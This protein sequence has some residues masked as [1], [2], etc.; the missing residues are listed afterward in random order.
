MKILWVEDFGGKLA[1]SKIAAAVFGELL[2]QVDLGKILKQGK[3]NVICQLPEL[4]EKHSIHQL[5]ICGSY[6]DWKRIYAEQAGDFD[7]VL[8]DINLEASRT[9]TDLMPGRIADRDFD[10]KAGFYIYHQLIKDG[11]PDDNIAFFTGEAQSLEDFTSYC[12]EI[13]LD[14]PKHCFEKDR[15]HFEKLRQWTAQKASREDLILRRG[16]IEGCHSIRDHIESISGEDLE[17]ELIV[18]KAIPGTISSHSEELRRESIEYLSRL[19][20][21]FLPNQRQNESDLYWLFIKEL[22]AKWEETRWFYL[23]HKAPAK[24]DDWL[25]ELF[26]KTA[27]FQMKMLRNWSNHRSLSRNLG[28]KDVAY[29]FIQAMRAWVKS[30]LNKPARYEEILTTL[31]T[32]LSIPELDRLINSSLAFHLES[33]YE[34]LK[35]LHKDVLRLTQEYLD[36]VRTRFNLN[37]RIDNYFLALFRELGE[38]LDTLEQNGRNERGEPI[39][40][41]VLA[42]CR[43]RINDVSVTLFYQSFWHGLFP[44][45]VKTVYYADLQTIRFN[46]EPLKIPYLS[47]LGRAIFDECFKDYEVSLK[48]A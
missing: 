42:Y 23:R 8:I 3:A 11:F 9:P 5:F 1:A 16:I 47:F 6:V 41:S 2:D 43:R 21:F 25:E 28:A 32:N 48:T 22:S 18:Y 12:G 14:P 38:L 30:D 19:E 27:H 39:D 24:F 40:P 34:Q 7:I 29:F 13:F 36:D 15:L 31:F 33:S 35:A 26:H 17:S 4:F 45:Q 20:R 37:R 10:K 46:I 44:L